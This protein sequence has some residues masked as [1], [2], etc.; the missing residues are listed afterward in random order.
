VELADLVRWG[1][2]LAFGQVC[3]SDVELS[4]DAGLWRNGARGV[5]VLCTPSR[6]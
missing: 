6:S 4:F 5:E 3:G 2:G 1:F